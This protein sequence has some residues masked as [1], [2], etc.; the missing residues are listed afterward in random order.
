MEF[1]T[2]DSLFISIYLIILLMSVCG[3]FW[4]VH[5]KMAIW[6]TMAQAH[7]AS[8]GIICTATFHT[9]FVSVWILN[10]RKSH[11][12]KATRKISE[13]A[14]HADKKPWANKTS[15][16]IEISVFISFLPDFMYCYIVSF[17]FLRVPQI[18]DFQSGS[19]WT[20]GVKGGCRRESKMKTK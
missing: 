20:P 14:T 6:W 7:L 9:M 2:I 12:D 17:E 3:W 5:S 10:V 8:W 1:S 18:R 16:Q 19:K 11:A 15:R 13:A 4:L